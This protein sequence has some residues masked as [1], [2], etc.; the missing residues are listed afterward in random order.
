M[1]LKVGDLLFSEDVLIYVTL[2]IGPSPVSFGGVMKGDDAKELQRRLKL[3]AQEGGVSYLA[4]DKN[5]VELTGFCRII[6]LNFEEL[7]TRPVMIR[8]SGKLAHPFA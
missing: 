3:L 1:K 7:A 2:M 6:D 5:G 4:V 8:F